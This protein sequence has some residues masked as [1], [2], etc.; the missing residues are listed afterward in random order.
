M[1]ERIVPLMYTFICFVKSVGRFV[2][3][4]LLFSW[5]KDSETCPPKHNFLKVYFCCRKLRLGFS[6]PALAA[7]P[8][9]CS[10]GSQE[11]VLAVIFDLFWFPKDWTSRNRASYIESNHWSTSI[12]SYD[13]QGPSSGI[14]AW[15][16]PPASLRWW[17][18]C[19]GPSVVFVTIWKPGMACPGEKAEWMSHIV[20][21]FTNWVDVYL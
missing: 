10:L 2:L 9:K 14:Q 21:V 4:L 17:K 1:T 5:L 20:P 18:L 12:V 13:W 16:Y 6:W 8:G 15:F 19:L 3:V 11:E 7:I